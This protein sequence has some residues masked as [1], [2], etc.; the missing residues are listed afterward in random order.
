MIIN[1][2]AYTTYVTGTQINTNEDALAPTGIAEANTI[3]RGNSSPGLLG[4]QA[5]GT[6]IAT[7]STDAT[8][9]TYSVLFTANSSNN[10]LL[11][12]YYPVVSGASYTI[13]FWAK[14]PIGTAQKF[15]ITNATPAISLVNISALTWTFFTYTVEST[16]TGWGQLYFYPSRFGA[17]GDTLLIDGLSIL[18]L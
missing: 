10:T 1:S 2:Y 15:S 7:V 18:E 16:I 8:L 13:S 9:G 3:I 11:R 12:F 17:I 14:S 6:T 4:L 5:D